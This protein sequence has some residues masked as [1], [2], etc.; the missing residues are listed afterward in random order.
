[1]CGGEKG[2]RMGGEEGGEGVCTMCV[3]ERVCTCIWVERKGERVC[4]WR[5]RG[6]MYMYVYWG[7][8]VYMGEEGGERVCV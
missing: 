1:M 6:C 8:G 5:G 3:G 2:V 4:V 7:N